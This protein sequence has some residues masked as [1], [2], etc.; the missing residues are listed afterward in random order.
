MIVRLHLYFSPSGVTPIQSPVNGLG[1][2]HLLGSPFRI[3][4]AVPTETGLINRQCLFADN[5]VPVSR[6]PPVHRRT[7]AMPCCRASLHVIR[8]FPFVSHR[9][10]APPV[11]GAAALGVG[12]ATCACP[13]ATTISVELHPDRTQG[14]IT[15]NVLTSTRYRDSD[16][17]FLMKTTQICLSAPD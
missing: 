16:S 14:K 11:L 1:L 8:P 7:G 13:S 12:S 6:M 2:L 3:R 5:P 10:S 4:L 15:K 9:F 17:D